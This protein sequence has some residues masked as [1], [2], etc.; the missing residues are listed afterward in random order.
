MTLPPLYKYLNVDGARK[1]LGNKCF[2]FAK[3]SEYE[4]LEDMTA[5]SLFPDELETALEMLQDGFVGVIVD[6]PDAVPTCSE[7]LKPAVVELQ[8]MFRENPALAD[9]VKEG[10]KKDPDSNGFNIEHWRTRSEAFVKEINDFMQGHRVLCVTTD[11]ASDRMWKEYAKDSQGIVLRIEPSL[12][13]DSKFQK[14]APVIYQEKRPAIFPRTLDYAK[15]VLFGDHLARARESMDGIIYAKTND[16]KF[17]SEY[18]L[19]IPLGEGEEDYRVLGYHPEE[20]TE[21]YLGSAMTEA[22]KKEVVSMAKAVNPNIAVFQ[23]KREGEGL[24]TFDKV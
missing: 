13:K 7:K 1:T 20:I 2:R 23:A 8:K 24:I 10:L 22:D 3:P 21:L 6:N 5:Q 18:R 15:E 4:D 14:F 9:V 17:E 11:K 19:A 16:Y 12:S